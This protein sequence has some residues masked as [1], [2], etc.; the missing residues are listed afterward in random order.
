M[1]SFMAKTEI[2]RGR[3]KGKAAVGYAMGLSDSE[4]NDS[5]SET[6]DTVYVFSVVVDCAKGTVV[7][8]NFLSAAHT[9]IS[10]SES[11]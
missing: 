4:I 11:N 1:A 6:M 5:Y 2:Y 9:L 8:Y 10:H 7:F 3:I